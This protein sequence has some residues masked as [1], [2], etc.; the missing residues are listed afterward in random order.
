M[1]KECECKVANPILKE[2]ETQFYCSKCEKILKIS[3]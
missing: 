1:L 3:Y 2:D